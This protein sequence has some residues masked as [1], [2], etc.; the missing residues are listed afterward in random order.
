MSKNSKKVVTTNTVLT[1]PNSRRLFAYLIDQ[2]ILIIGSGFILALFGVKVLSVETIPAYLSIVV[3]TLVYRILVP[4]FVFRG[5]HTGQTVG[6]RLMGIKVISVNG[7]QVSL[8][9]L[10]IRSL[11]GLI[12]EGFDFYSV[13]SLYNAIGFINRIK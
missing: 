3:L 13:I 1:A 5:E 2:I 12:I 9:S 6:K 10:T 4:I 7:T 8:S 11:F